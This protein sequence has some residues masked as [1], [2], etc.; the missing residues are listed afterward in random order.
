MLV[1]RRID[2]NIFFQRFVNNKIFNAIVRRENKFNSSF[3]LFLLR[4]S[5]RR[6]LFRARNNPT[7]LIVQDFPTNIVKHASWWN[8]DGRTAGTRATSRLQ[9]KSRTRDRSVYPVRSQFYKKNQVNRLMFV[10]GGHTFGHVYR[11]VTVLYDSR[12]NNLDKC[13]GSRKVHGG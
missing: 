5:E 3:N 11:L 12:P 1:E 10:K 8:T 4:N 7:R 6:E 9:F 2:R 13:N